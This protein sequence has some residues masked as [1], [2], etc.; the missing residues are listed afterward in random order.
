MLVPVLTKALGASAKHSQIVPQMFE[1]DLY[2]GFDM[3]TTEL[4]S[5]F[6]GIIDDAAS[7][8]RT[9]F[10]VYMLMVSA[11]Q[12]IQG[13]CTVGVREAMQCE[14]GRQGKGRG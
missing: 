13:S 4:D 14:V 12:F 5:E 1:G 9:L 2:Q 10:V 6:E 3:I 7:S 8:N 11:A